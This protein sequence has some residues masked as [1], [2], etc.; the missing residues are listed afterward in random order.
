MMD[1]YRSMWE[2]FGREKSVTY[3]TYKFQPTHRVGLTNFLREEHMAAWLAPQ[4]TDAVLDVGC[5]SGRQLFALADHLREGQGVD[6]AQSFIDEAERERIKKGWTHLGFRQAMI[7]ALPFEDN[8]FDRV[9]CGE[10]LEHV[11]DKDRAL[12]ELL[13]VLKPGGTLVISVPNMNADATAWGRLLRWLGLRTFRSLEHFS[14]E[15][16]MKHGDAHVREFTVATLRSWL[17]DTGLSVRRLT[18]VSFIDG[19]GFDAALK[20]PLHIP[21]LRRFLLRVERWC[22][23]RHW[24]WGRHL[25]IEAVKTR[26]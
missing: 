11:F 17:E 9:L 7:E 25:I 5:A 18:S 10:V 16:I 21:V 19:P 15:E 23:G 13:R 8:A 4:P 6:I 2:G 12:T 14:R 20:I 1:A 3:L 22:A 24:T 26:V